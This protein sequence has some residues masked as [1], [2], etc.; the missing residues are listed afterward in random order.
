MSTRGRFAPYV[1]GVALLAVGGAAAAFTLYAYLLGEPT[2]GFLVTAA[3]AALPGA[4]LRYIG[5]AAA[6]PTRREALAAVL[7][8][9]FLVPL[10]GCIPFALT[11]Q[12]SFVDGLFE[13]VSGFTATGA[14][15]ITDFTVL[16]ASLIVWRALSQ[17]I[18]GIGIIVMFVAVFPQLAIAGRQMF[19]TEVPGPVEDRLA[20]RLRSTAGA[21]LAVYTALTVA[22]AA[23]Y[24]AFGMSTFDALMHSLTTVAAGGFSHYPDGFAAFASANLEWVAVLFMFLA[25]VSLPLIFRTVN[26]RP[27]LPLR[28]VE[29][30]V[31]SLIIAVAAVG[32]WLVL[33]S[34]GLDQAFRRGVFHVVSIM[35]TTG[36]ASVDFAAW[37]PPA[38]A[39]LLLLMLIGG[40]AGS[41]SGGVKVA[42]WLIVAKNTMREVAKVLH[43][44]AVMPVRV[45]R[46]IV[47]DDVLRSVAAFITLYVSLVAVITVLLVLLGSSLDEALTAALACIG[48]VGPGF[49]SLGPYGSYAELHPAAR[50]LLTFGM[51]VGRLEVVT[52]FVVF[53]PSWWRLPRRNPLNWWRWR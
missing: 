41:A 42:R 51:V 38:Q 2:S 24:L 7:L 36:F 16:P 3:V 13:S 25:G 47:S 31:Y 53:L 21:V 22:C 52:V 10:I 35:T 46:R 15:V 1:L 6:E 29:F 37:A 4:V 9:W 27:L 23:G 43:P 34:A 20:P 30:R 45:G 32:L 5:L 28:N 39:I 12:L 40:S 33:A 26:G 49:G 17:W 19:F 48:N 18:G 8:T 50:L 11:S 44:R 14:T